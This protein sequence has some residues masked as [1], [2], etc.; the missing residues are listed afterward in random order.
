VLQRDSGICHI[1]KRAGANEVDHIVA[2]D[3]HSMGNLG[4][5]HWACHRKKSSAEGHAARRATRDL[6]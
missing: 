2:G 5:V 1:C 6:G 4:A 3:D